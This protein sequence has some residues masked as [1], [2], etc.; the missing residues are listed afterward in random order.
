MQM[1]GIQLK[2]I[3]VCLQKSEKKEKL[4]V[5]TNLLHPLCPWNLFPYLT[6]LQTMGSYMNKRFLDKYESVFSG[7]CFCNVLSFSHWFEEGGAQWEKGI[8]THFCA[9]IT[10]WQNFI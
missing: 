6:L 4:I 8:V 10:I 7:E 1:K 5:E 9:A 2:Y 3:F